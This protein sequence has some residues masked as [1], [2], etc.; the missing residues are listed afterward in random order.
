MAYNP[1]NLGSNSSSKESLDSSLR[2]INDMLGE[3]YTLPFELGEGIEFN[4]DFNRLQNVPS[5]LLNITD[6]NFY[7]WNE[8]FEWGNH[9]DQ[10][11]LTTADAFPV[12]TFIFNESTISTSDDST[13]VIA[14]DVNIDGS[15][16]VQEDLNVIGTLSVE[17]LETNG[18]GSSE[19][20]AATNLDLTAGNAVRIT[21]S[22][23]RLSNFTT[24]ERNAL[25]A[26][27]GDVIYNTTSNKFQGYANGVWVDLH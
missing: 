23:L 2:K 10:G 17:S 12:G 22:A 3:L 13:I 6:Q 4:L 27:N 8:A 18:T 7:N 15:L 21:S 19:I 1:L 9:A 5:V 24:T 14:R 11:Y 20:T 16:T 26:Q 25:P